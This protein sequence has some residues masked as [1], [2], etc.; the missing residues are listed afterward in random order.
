MSTFWKTKIPQIMVLFFLLTLDF[1]LSSAATNNSA[2][3][4]NEKRW[5]VFTGDGHAGDC[6]CQ[7]DD[8]RC[9]QRLGQW[10]PWGEYRCSYSHER[11]HGLADKHAP[12]HLM[13]DHVHDQ[14]E[15]MVEYKYMSMAMAGN[16]SGTENLSTAAAF[17][18]S[19]TN[20]LVAPTN[21]TMEMHMVHVMYGLRDNITAYLMPTWKSLT[22]DHMRNSTFM[23]N[24]PLAGTPFRTH[25]SGFG[26]LVFGAL[27]R[28]YEGCDEELIF[29]LGMSV[30]TGDIDRRTT[31]PTG[32]MMNQEFPY[33]MRLGAGTFNARPGLTYKVY[34]DHGSFGLQYQTDLP[35]G[36][37]SENYSVST[38]HRLNA[39]YSWLP[40]DNL[41]FSYRVESLW[42]SDYNGADPDLPPF[43]ISTNRPDMRGGE[44]VNFG[45]GAALL[46]GQ[47][48]L[49][50]AEFVHPVYQS[51]NGIQ[52]ANDWSLCVSW[53]KAF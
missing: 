8:L 27:I 33:P 53:S 18:F 39:W 17:G 46:V 36:T 6:Q 5:A 16:R 19:G 13:G 50:N 1:A 2:N 37:N 3:D 47:G 34:Q 40:W 44:W 32:G 7:G 29:N 31:I 48:H 4:S 52:L 45:Y 15:W 23:P 10:D 25:N 42:K 30:P 41:S 38:E 43:I 9:V 12:A 49:L 24:P 26:D 28:L 20:M 22:M 14:G 51:V 35:V 11:R 21:M